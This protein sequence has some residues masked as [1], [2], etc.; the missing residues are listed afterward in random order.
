MDKGEYEQ[1]IPL[2]QF[3]ATTYA[4]AQK[5]EGDSWSRFSAD[6]VLGMA[7]CWDKLKQPEAAVS[8]YHWASGEYIS[9]IEYDPKADR[10]GMK[11]CVDEY[12]AVLKKLGQAAQA[13]AMQAEFKRTGALTFD[14]LPQPP[15]RSNPWTPGRLEKHQ[16]Q[17]STQVR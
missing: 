2:F 3:C 8:Y 9:A 16:Q 14:T 11:Q 13:D 6:S 15:K 7:E 1:A 4:D 12:A 5:R 17:E 10:S